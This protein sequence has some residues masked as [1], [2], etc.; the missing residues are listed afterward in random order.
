MLIRTRHTTAG[1]EV[2]YGYKYV[3]FRPKRK[4]IVK[5]RLPLIIKTCG[6]NWM[7]RLVLRCM[8]ASPLR[9]RILN[10]I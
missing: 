2:F 1:R 9:H 3:G 5:Q 6:G 4:L 10:H 8:S 7:R